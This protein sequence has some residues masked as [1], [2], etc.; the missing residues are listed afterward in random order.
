[1]NLFHDADISNII[2]EL[3]MGR[4]FDDTVMN[5]IVKSF[6]AKFGT[7]ISARQGIVQDLNRCH[8]RNI[9]HIRRL[10]TPLPA[11][12]KSLA[13]RKLPVLNGDLLS[14]KSPDGGNVGIINHLA[15]IARVTN[16]IDE[17]DIYNALMDTDV[18]KLDNVFLPNFIILQKY[19]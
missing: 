4:I 6:G 10:S 9:S 12:S 8:V 1:M 13:P 18:Y 17:N 16:N 7:G 11:G 19:F 5:T 2:N 14:Y 15:I 3:N